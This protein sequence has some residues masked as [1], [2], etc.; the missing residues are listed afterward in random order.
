MVVQ[1]FTP[2]RKLPTLVVLA[3]LPLFFYPI[4]L[5]LAILSDT[6]S[7]DKNFIFSL[8]Y[9]SLHKL[10]TTILSDWRASL[11]IA[12][13]IVI[14]MLFPIQLVLQRL[15]FSNGAILPLLAGLGGGLFS[16]WLY[17]RDAWH[18]IIFIL[19]GAMFAGL[20]QVSMWSARTVSMRFKT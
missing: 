11:P 13:I 17:D 9:D 12:Y 5:G 7:G 6:A 2:M 19:S 8:T 10:R 18:S 14:F 16:Y 1:V 3:I 15:R 4:F 20:F